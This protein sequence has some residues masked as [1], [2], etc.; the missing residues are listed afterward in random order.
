MYAV[1]LRR[2]RKICRIEKLLA[3]LRLLKLKPDVI[4]VLRDITRYY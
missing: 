1:L 4:K 2:L 3:I